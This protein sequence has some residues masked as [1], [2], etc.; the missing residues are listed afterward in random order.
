VIVGDGPER[1]ALQALAENLGVASS[2]TFA[3]H[4]EQTP[5]AYRGFDVFALSSDTE[6]MPLS[7]L[8]A[9]AAGLPVA[10]TDVGDVAAML[11]EANRPFVSALDDTALAAAIKTLLERPELRAALG[12]ANRARAERDYDEATMVRGYA[13]LFGA[14]S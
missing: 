8:E 11:A 9:M 10:A 2:T 6:Q 5:R 12:A 7:V 4:L 3:G 1:P 14:Q 13:A